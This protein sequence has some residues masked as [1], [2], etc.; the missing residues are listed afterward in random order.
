MT[1]AII[2]EDELPA[3][4]TIKIFLE[5]YFEE[6]QVVG[7]F[8]SKAGALDFISEN[9]VEIVFLD[10]QLSDGLGLDLLK[11]IDTDKYRIVF[12]TAH[13]DYAMEAFKY[14]AFGYLLKPLDPEDFQ[15]IMKRVLVDIGL[16]KTGDVIKIPISNGNVWI[17]TNDI[18][19]CESENNYCVI[20]TEDKSYLIS[21][22]LNLW[23]VYCW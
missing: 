10:V 9:D 23:I 18:V 12:I 8:D 13:E 15:D 5:K 4:V 14:K 11:L 17:N 21:K 6:I 20:Y 3:R 22:T 7:E 16:S 1:R 19:R 2:I